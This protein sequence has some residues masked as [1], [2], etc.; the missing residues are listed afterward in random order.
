M[1][2][3][4]I[5]LIIL[6]CASVEKKQASP[7]YYYENGQVAIQESLQYAIQNKVMEPDFEKCLI[8]GKQEVVKVDI[9]AKILPSGELGFLRAVSSSS[10]QKVKDCIK[11]YLSSILF[12]RVPGGD[13]VNFKQ[14]FVFKIS[15]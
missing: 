15:P 8:H 1:S 9:E 4:L 13:V 2:L 5:F 12:N 6:S 7:W 10:N 3:F 14:R 11:T